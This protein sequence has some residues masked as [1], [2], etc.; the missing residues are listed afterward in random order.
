MGIEEVFDHSFETSILIVSIILLPY[1]LVYKYH[2]FVLVLT[3]FTEIFGNLI[4]PFLGTLFISY[5]NSQQFVSKVRSSNHLSPQE[6][7]KCP[8]WDHPNSCQQHKL[9][10]I[11]S[12]VRSSKQLSATY[13]TLCLKWDLLNACQQH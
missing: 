7:T 1:F 9:T 3:V 8:K 12:K 11:A 13:V 6:L 5:K 4:T 2:L 10:L